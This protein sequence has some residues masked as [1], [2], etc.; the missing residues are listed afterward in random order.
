LPVHDVEPSP[1]P[2]EPPPTL[3]RW[4]VLYALVIAGLLA[5]ILLCGALTRWGSR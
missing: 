3:G 2:D 4:P 1:S 5:M